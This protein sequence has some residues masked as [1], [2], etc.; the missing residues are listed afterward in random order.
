MTNLNYLGL[1][2][3]NYTGENVPLAVDYSGA[4]IT[5]DQNYVLTYADDTN[6]Y[7]GYLTGAGRWLIKRITESNGVLTIKFKKGDLNFQTAWSNR[8]SSN[9]DYVFYN[10]L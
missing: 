6:G 2:G 3:Q 8:A 4:L 9:N 7:Y 5:S 1:T 10:D